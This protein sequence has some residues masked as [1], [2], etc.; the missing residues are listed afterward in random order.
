MCFEAVGAEQ[1]PFKGRASRLEL[2]L[3]HYLTLICEQALFAIKQNT[4]TSLK[5][6]ENNLKTAMGSLQ[7]VQMLLYS[8][9]TT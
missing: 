2:I 4:T 3:K 1:V 7:S 9:D 8:S 5:M 6:D